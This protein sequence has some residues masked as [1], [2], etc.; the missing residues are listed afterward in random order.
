VVHNI[1]KSYT[2]YFDLFSEMLQNA[3]DALELRTRVDGRE[4]RPK[5][6]ITID[7]PA[8]LVR[9]V[10][11]GVGMDEEQLK[12]CV[13]PSVS[14]KTNSK[15]RGQKGVGATFL[16]YGFS[17][18]KLQSKSEHVGIAAILRQGRQ[19]ADD[20]GDTV[21][22]PKFEGVAFGVPE[23]ASEKSGTSI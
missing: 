6:W 1:L 16:A 10:D 11:N 4:Y 22:R 3:L 2:G 7:I 9:V 23:L 12:F 18:I 19:W 15:L 20:Q 8:G 14:F 5:L 21:P 13:T 17:F